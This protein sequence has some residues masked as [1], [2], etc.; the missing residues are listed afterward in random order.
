MSECATPESAGFS[1]ERLGRVNR[2]M[3]AY[4]DEGKLAGALTLLARGGETFHFGSY[5]AQDLASGVPVGR[6]TIFRLY[7]MTKPITSVAAMMLYEEGR[8]SLDDPVG[9]FIP[10]FSDTQVFDGMG[11]T[12]MRL[13]SQE[14]PITI[15]HLLTHTSGLSYGLLKDTPIDAMYHEA[16]IADA[17][18][19]LKDVMGR[20]AEIPLVNQPGAK[21]R[22]GMSSTVLGYLVEVVSGMAFDEFLREKLFAPLG[23]DDTSFFVPEGKL[24]RLATAYLPSRGGGI[25]PHEGSVSSRHRRPHAMQSGGAG[26]VSTAEDYLRFC[27]MLLN[28]GEL[29]GERVLAPKTAQLMRSDHLNEDL[30]PY[31]VEERLA[32]YTKGCGFGLGFSIVNDIAQHGIPGSEGMYGWFGAASCYFWID[33]A[34]ELIA[35]LMTQF[36]PVTWYPLRRE[37]QTATYGA[38]VD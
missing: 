20:L 10:E 7:S 28:G 23:M 4:V 24:D 38:L 11:E 8:F 19:A 31:I 16:R 13:V 15:R 36:M 2:M 32:A 25:T 9:K 3:Q 30:K 27:Q 21:W 17:D 34:E 5:G 12:G 29:D 35:I 33:P 14:R 6:D 1:S 26:L 22:Y 18:S 37:F